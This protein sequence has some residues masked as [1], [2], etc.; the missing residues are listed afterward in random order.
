MQAVKRHPEENQRTVQLLK[1]GENEAKK[2]TLRSRGRLIL[3][4]NQKK[5]SWNYKEIL[6]EAY[7]WKSWVL[8]KATLTFC[9]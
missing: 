1:M 5:M 4:R 7:P 8:V 2:K 6:E 9:L 3:V